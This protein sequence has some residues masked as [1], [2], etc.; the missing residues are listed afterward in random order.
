MDL[1]TLEEEAL[2][3]PAADRAKLARELLESLDA[4]SPRELEVLWTEEAERR[5]REIDAGVVQTVPGDDVIRKA[6]TL[7]R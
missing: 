4:L 2:N 6:R 7:V 5:A 3:L 1:K